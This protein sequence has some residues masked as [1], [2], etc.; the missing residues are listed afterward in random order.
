M[1]RGELGE[2][3]KKDICIVKIRMEANVSN[4]RVLK[5]QLMKTDSI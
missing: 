2:E 1:E 3:E 4:K 5:V